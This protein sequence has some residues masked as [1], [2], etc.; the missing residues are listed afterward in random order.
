MEAASG[1]SVPS[2]SVAYLAYP[3]TQR[4]DARRMPSACVYTEDSS[5]QGL[6]V[7]RKTKYEMEIELL[8]LKKRYASRASCRT[9]LI[10]C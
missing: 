2:V 7:K 9:R 8:M 10:L 3:R 5:F 6:P 1:A 4:A